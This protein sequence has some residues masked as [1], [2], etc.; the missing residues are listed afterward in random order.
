MA[1]TTALSR[2]FSFS[3]LRMADVIREYRVKKTKKEIIE[4][5]RV[6]LDDF[7]SGILSSDIIRSRV[8]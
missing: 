6:L 8:T 2:K 7:I 3:A 5:I 4:K 1:F